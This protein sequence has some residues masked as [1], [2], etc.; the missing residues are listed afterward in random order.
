MNIY[1]VIGYLIYLP[2]SFYITFFVGQALYKSGA[3]FLVGSFHGDIT[4]ASI[5]NR[6]LLTGYYLINLGYAVGSISLWKNIQ[7]DVELI[8]EVSFR[9]GI[10]ISGLAL[11]HFFNLFF[12][13]HFSKAIQSLYQHKHV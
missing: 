10:L 12:F 13:T 7:Y 8:E 4:L 1:N 6:F 11:M 2:V 5:T 3:V 9:L